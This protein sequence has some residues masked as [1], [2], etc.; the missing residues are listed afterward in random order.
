MDNIVPIEKQKI[1]KDL[2]LLKIHIELAGISPMI[3]RR[4]LILNII[5]L[6]K[7]HTIIQLAFAWRDCHLRNPIIYR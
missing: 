7:L 6:E 4:I 1:K 5:T 3:W 2:E